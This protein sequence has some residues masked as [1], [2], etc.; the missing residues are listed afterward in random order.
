MN[1]IIVND[2]D[3]IQGGAS[4]VAI[5][6]ANLLYEKKVNTYFFS[7]VHSNES[8]IKSNVINLNQKEMIK[9]PNKIRGIFN[10]LFNVRALIEFNHLLEQFDPLDT[11]I[12]VHGW[13]KALSSS[14]FYIAF[15]KN[16]KVVITAHDYF[17][18]CPNGGL[19][20]YQT[21]NSCNLKPL[22]KKCLI[23]NCDS[24]NMFF[25][26]FR[27]IRHVIQNKIIKLPN[28]LQYII[29]I[30]Q[31]SENIIKE[32]LNSDFIY[33]IYNPTSITIKHPIIELKPN[34][35]F[36]YVG[37]LSKE[38]GI[39]E[40]LEAISTTKHE[41]LV[42]GDGPEKEQL[43]ACYSD[44]KNIH[45]TGWKSQEEVIKLMRQ[46]KALI[47]PSLWYEGAPLV[48]F[49]A[50]SI[51]LPCL[52]SNKC[53]AIDFIINNKD[54]KWFNPNNKHSIINALNISI[55]DLKTFSVHSY[56]KYWENPFTEE[57][58]INSLIEIYSKILK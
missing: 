39:Y 38:K 16:F 7:A 40:L 22:S 54:G 29:T 18:P 3:Y 55:N 10:N 48:L 51:G 32:Y 19:F 6:T 33:R 42:V 35:P 8:K 31:F 27:I 56:K 30:S 26:I 37:R 21:N 12:H 53:S 17:I 4:K 52:V 28:K 46:A 36:I 24:R 2:F 11:I 50:M 44:Y 45:F 20:N 9:D 41:L 13:T 14:I 34:K 15:K 57:R 43:V 23:C 25:K 58:Y 49:E 5:E 1:V 47:L